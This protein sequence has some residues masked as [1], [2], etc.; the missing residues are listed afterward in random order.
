MNSDDAKKPEKEG[1]ITREFR[2]K[3][4]KI[5]AYY[6]IVIAADIIQPIYHFIA[7][8]ESMD[9][10]L[11]DV[12]LGILTMMRQVSL[13]IEKVPTVDVRIHISSTMN[14]FLH[15]QSTIYSRLALFMLPAA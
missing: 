5:A 15:N 8:M 9:A 12:Q 3:C 2:E 14:L 6:P 11:V 13:E 7:N 10:N 4:N 1:G